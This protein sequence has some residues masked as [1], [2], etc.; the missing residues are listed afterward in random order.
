MGQEQEKQA[1]AAQRLAAFEMGIGR[2]CADYNVSFDDLAK[3]AGVVP[4]ALGPSLVQ[5]L[6]DSLKNE[7]QA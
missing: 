1:E 5:V 4:D 7:Q 3:T 2:R 6:V